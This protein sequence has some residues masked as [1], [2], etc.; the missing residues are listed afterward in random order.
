M[1]AGLE[2]EHNFQE[3]DDIDWDAGIAG[4]I[5][6]LAKG[7]FGEGPFEVLGLS[8]GRRLGSEEEKFVYLSKKHQMVD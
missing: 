8:I 1:P 6:R 7:R 2:G 3:G 4:I 5:V